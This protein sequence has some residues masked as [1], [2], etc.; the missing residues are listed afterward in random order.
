[1]ILGAQIL[2]GFQYQVL[3]NPG[4]ARLPSWG[5]TLDSVALGLTLVTAVFL[6]AC[7]P[8]HRL[9]E[10]GDDTLRLVHQAS[11]TAA[12]ALGS[13]ALAV[14]A[15]FALVMEH[16]MSPL[17]SLL[18]GVLAL[19]VCLGF[20][21]L[22]GLARR[23]ASK[24]QGGRVSSSLKDRISLL[25]TESRVILPG[26][27]A[28]LGIQFVAVFTDRFQQLP[29]MSQA[30]HMICLALLALAM[31]ML[32]APAAYHRLVAGGD[33]TDGADRF[34]V[35]MVLG[36]LI[37]LGLGMTGDFYVVVAQVTGSPGWGI[38]WSAALLLLM[39]GLWLAWPLAARRTG[40]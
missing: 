31:V 36:S 25:L 37:P 29:E 17:M 33:A 3:F 21:F 4:F 38:G 16:V 15:D 27:Q 13:T 28:L 34:G 39:L 8:Y 9:A 12:C 30:V 6:L 35:R 2:I 24:K 32:L 14:G 18:S 19:L 11:L 1:M 20:W 22:H 23:R 5:R 7:I 26:C 10:N 40:G